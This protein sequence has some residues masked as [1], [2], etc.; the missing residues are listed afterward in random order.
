MT[1]E[2]VISHYGNGIN[3]AKALKISPSSI[4]QWG[5]KGSVPFETQYRIEVLTGGVLKADGISQKNTP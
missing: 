2:D 1:Y 5:R 3:V 4:Y